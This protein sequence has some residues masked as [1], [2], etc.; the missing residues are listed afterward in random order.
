VYISLIHVLVYFMCWEPD[1]LSIVVL[2]VEVAELS[3][4]AS[5]Y[6]LLMCSHCGVEV[7]ELS[8][9]ASSYL[10]LMCSHCGVEVTE[11]STYAS[12]Y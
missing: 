4:C 2:G 6:L 9:Y 7:T 8:T 1:F 12:S 5:S 11:L 10:L 3:T